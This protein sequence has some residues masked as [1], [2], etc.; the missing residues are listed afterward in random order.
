MSAEWTFHKFNFNAGVV[1]YPN[2]ACQQ[3]RRKN[4]EGEQP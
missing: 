3:Q 1:K 4:E 2:R